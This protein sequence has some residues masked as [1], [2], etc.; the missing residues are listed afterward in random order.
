MVVTSSG[1]H[2]RPSACHKP[3]LDFANL[4]FQNGGWDKL[5][6]YGLTKL[7]EIMMIRGLFLIGAIPETTTALTLHPGVVSTKLLTQAGFGDKGIPLE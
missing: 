4:Q 3:K 7:L 1:L 2:A 6:S 5:G